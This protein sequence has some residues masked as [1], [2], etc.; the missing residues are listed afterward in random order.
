MEGFDT[1]QIG[2]FSGGPKDPDLFHTIDELKGTFSEMNF[3]ILRKQEITLNEG[4]L[5]QGKAVV[6]RVMGRKI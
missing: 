1:E 2:R 6:I 3:E 4:P 5:H